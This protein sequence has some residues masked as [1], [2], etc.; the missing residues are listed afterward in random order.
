MIMNNLFVIWLSDES[1]LNP[2]IGLEHC[3]QTLR[4]FKQ[5]LN[6]HRILVETML[7]E[8]MQ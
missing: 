8:V 4:S 7:N 5:G 1:M 6:Q 2:I 3:S